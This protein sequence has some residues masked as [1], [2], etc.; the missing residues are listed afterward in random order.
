MTFQIDMTKAI[1]A[2]R[3]QLMD[4]GIV[5]DSIIADGEIHRCGTAGKE[6]GKDGAYLFHPDPPHG[7]WYL[8]YRTGESGKGA[9]GSRTSPTSAESKRLQ[10]R[11]EKD[12]A[13]RQTE[14]IQRQTAAAK[15]AVKAVETLPCATGKHPYLIKKGVKPVGDLRVE[16]N[17]L[18]VPVLDE[19]GHPQSLQRI[20][21]DG[22]KQFIKDGKTKGGYFPIKGNAGSIY[23][24]EGLATGL[25]VYEATGKTI[26]CA[27]NA[28]NLKNVAQLA[29]NKYPNREIIIAGDN[30]RATERNPGL[31]KAHEATQAIKG[32]LTIPEFPPNIP[33]SDFNDLHT[34]MGIEEVKRQIQETEEITLSDNTEADPPHDNNVMRPPADFPR[35]IFPPEIEASLLAAAAA[36]NVPYTVPAV[37]L[38]VAAAAAI[39]RTRSLIVKNGWEV[40]AN[41]Y[42]AIVA[43]S[44][45]GKTPCSS[46]IMRPLR[47]Q[48]YECYQNY[49][50]EYEAY[51]AKKAK[52]AKETKRNRATSKD[53]PKPVQPSQ[54]EIFLDDATMEKVGKTLEANPRGILW[55]RDE[56]AGLFSDLGK[57]S[58]KGKDTGDKARLLSAYNCGPWKTSRATQKDVYVPAACI[59]LFGTIQPNVMKRCFSEEDKQSGLTQRMIFIRCERHT[60][61]LWIEDEYD[62]LAAK[63]VVGALE[64]LL[65]L[66]LRENDEPHEIHFSKDAKSAFVKWFNDKAWEIHNTPELQRYKTLLPKQQEQ[67]FKLSLTLH[68]LECWANGQDDNDLISVKTVNRAIALT[69]WIIT[70][71][72]QVWDMLDGQKLA[73]QPTT[74]NRRV[75][76]AIIELKEEFQNGHLP[77]ARITEHINVGAPQEFAI[78]SQSVGK[79]YK[80]L[81]LTAERDSSGRRAVAVSTE[82]M[83][84]LED[85][86]ADL[87]QDT[88]T[89]HDDI[90]VYNSNHETWDGSNEVEI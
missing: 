80:K 40:F 76:V 9:Y 69:N 84:R 10:E 26:L 70:H 89:L 86:Y 48:D 39:G 47:K 11:I 61:S 19:N 59:T 55:Y 34:H 5:T 46:K 43:E 32:M 64:F 52:W 74:L 49:Q 62:D 6:N 30:D 75:A 60:P 21:P 66:Q 56:L 65:G 13:N 78:N 45:L 79:V 14:R 63:P 27:F 15:K 20:S 7:G 53:S 35:G 25:T 88:S 57:Y 1:E 58:S 68:M 28:G 24:V 8:N 2:F 90:P 23:I 12:K 37:T 67:M 31:T 87:M 33:G 4:A 73:D 81:G 82:Q 42:L 41:I 44:G 85:D 51:E 29:R 50:L 22:K 54:K 71:Q 17:K 16:H 3:Q 36:F 18:V 38:L 72:R 77:T 83:V